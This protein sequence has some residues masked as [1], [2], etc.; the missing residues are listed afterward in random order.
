[1]QSEQNLIPAA[2][3]CTDLVLEAIIG[4]GQAVLHLPVGEHL[5]QL[6]H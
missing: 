6:L 2:S 3:Q 4:E 5:A 1:M